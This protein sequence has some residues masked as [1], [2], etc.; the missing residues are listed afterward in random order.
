[1]SRRRLWAALLGAAIG[2]SPVRAEDWPNWGRDGSR[3]MVSGEKNLPASFTPPQIR[4]DGSIDMA[5]AKSIKWVAKLGSAAYGN[6][7]VAGGRIFIGINND[8]PHLEKYS[9]DYGIVLCLDESSGKLLWQLSVPKLAAGQHCDYENVG[10]CSSPAVD[11]Q[12]VYVVTSRCEVLCLDVQGMANGN[13][14]PFKDEAQYVAGPGRPAIGQGPGDADI[15]W[16]YDMRDELGVFPHQ[17]TSS[18][19]LVV[20]DRLYVTT[21]NGQ[22]WTPRGH[23]P[24]PNA[25]ALICLDKNSGKLLGREASGI[26][27]RTFRCHWSSPALAKI[28]GKELIIFGADDGFCYAFDPVPAK[29]E[30]G[31]GILKE[32]WRFDCNPPE[33]RTKNGKPAK[34]G[35]PSGPSGIL[36][37]PVCKDGRVYVAIGQEPSDSQGQGPGCLSCIDASKSGDI[38]GSGKVWTRRIGRSIST[39]A[40]ADG[41]LYTADASG[42]LYCLDASSGEELWQQDTEGRIWGSPLVADGKVYI[43]NETGDLFV[44]GAGRE[45]KL[46]GKV[47]MPGA[48]CSSAVAA[49]GVLYIS[50]DKHLFAVKAEE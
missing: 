14:G 11:G 43:G 32:I 23:I 24:S 26:S 39:V 19:V 15:I 2:A 10:V 29:N 12:R 33:Y 20:G 44:V 46:L 3:N 1:M 21:S 18:A 47:K 40:L 28:G 49:N 17:M 22:D 13:D 30:A 36:A 9:G 6:A 42:F 8:P 31:E 16:R 34:Y 35:T 7:T 37:T 38:S 5:G 27:G 48:I 50:T 4:D 45:Q 41:L 25:P